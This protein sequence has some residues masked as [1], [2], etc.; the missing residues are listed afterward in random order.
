MRA[1]EVLG[2]S[3][4]D[5]SGF[6]FERDG[7]IYRQVNRRYAQSFAMLME[8]GLYEFLVSSGL[9]VEHRE[10]DISPPVPTLAA[11]VIR[12]EPIPFISYPYEWCFG[13]LKDA[14]LTTLDIQ[15]T[16][17]DCGMTLKDASAF[18]IQ[19]LEGRPVLIDSLSFNPYVE[20]CA[21]VAYRQFC[22]HFL[23]PLLLMSRVDPWL[24]RLAALTVD[25]IPLETTSRLLPTATW[26]RPTA[27]LHVHLHARSVRRFG[28][29]AV[30]RSLEAR[31]LSRRG[32]V[33]L[34]EGL[35]HSIERITWSPGGTE[36]SDYEADH[37]YSDEDMEEKHRIVAKLIGEAKPDTVWDLG[38]NTGAFSRIASRAGAFVVSADVDPAAVERNYQRAR[39]EADMRL[40]PLWIDLRNP[41]PA[42]GWGSRERK[43]LAERSTADIVLALALVHHLAIG[44]NV[45]FDMIFEFLARLGPELVVEFVPK[46]DP[47]TQ[48]LLVSREDV[49]EDYDQQTFEA[50]L[51]NDFVI[52]GVHEVGTSGR[53]VYRAKRREDRGA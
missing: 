40:H 2:A 10:V 11:H 41:T 3:F 31:G 50:A 42:L 52:T 38:A 25:G 45:P 37:G 46:E 53:T 19:F 39:S 9:L 7:C 30:P 14:A 18:N 1:K 43:S 44:A 29:R 6:V 27:L 36:W 4:R 24:G 32:M 23:A 21:W 51:E 33:N 35:K 13:Q 22:E 47:Q 5:P 34:I 17:L 15:L 20:G 12:P 49:F 28:G 48:R 8:S 26:L 16:A